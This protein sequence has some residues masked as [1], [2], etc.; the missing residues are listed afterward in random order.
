MAS[1]AAQQ[2]SARLRVALRVDR[3]VLFAAPVWA[4]HV[5]KTGPNDNHITDTVLIDGAETDIV[6]PDGTPLGRV[7]AAA[8]CSAPIRTGATS[9]CD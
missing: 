3:G 5:A 9:W 8:I 6:A 4:E 1:P 7:C 2:G